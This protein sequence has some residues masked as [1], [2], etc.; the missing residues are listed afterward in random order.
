MIAPVWS[1]A[2]WMPNPL[3]WPTTPV[4]SESSTSRAGPRIALPVRSAMISTAAICHV[5]TNARPGIAMRFIAYPAMTI[6]QYARVR[7]ANRPEK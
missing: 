2:A 3:P 4:A 5:C 7:S 6:G 1:I